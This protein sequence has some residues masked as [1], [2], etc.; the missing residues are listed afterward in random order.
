[1]HQLISTL[2]VVAEEKYSPC[3]MPWVQSPE[4]CP[5]LKVV[6]T[7]LWGKAILSIIEH[8]G[9]QCSQLL[10]VEDFFFFEIGLTM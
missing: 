10:Y 6:P 3:V 9:G 2:S 1:M 5:T 4:P 8:T 7:F